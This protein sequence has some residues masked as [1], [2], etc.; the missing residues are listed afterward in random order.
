MGY[1]LPI[2]SIKKIE[3]MSVLLPNYLL[4]LYYIE[5]LVIS[6]L[7]KTV[8]NGQNKDIEEKH[9]SNIKEMLGKDRVFK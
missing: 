9:I 1:Y 5:L 6:I 2:L 4:V 3:N 7:N 8:N